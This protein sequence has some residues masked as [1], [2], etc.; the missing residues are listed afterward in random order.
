MDVKTSE[1]QNKAIY[2]Q[3]IPLFVVLV[4]VVSMV[5]TYYFYTK[6]SETEAI[7]DLILAN[8]CLLIAIVFV[9]PIVEWRRVEID[10]KSIAIYKFF[11]RPI[12][13]NISQSLYQVIMNNDGIRSY[14][15]RVGDSYTQ[16]SPQAYVNGKSLSNRL[17]A[18]IAR[19]KLVIDAVY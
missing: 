8:V 19:N 5:S 10:D 1:T 15:F 18:H 3:A 2:H 12:R 16:I 11:F 9:K 4:T 17:D 7:F 13:I 6:F 14:R